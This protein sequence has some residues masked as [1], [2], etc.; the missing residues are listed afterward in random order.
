MMKN[1]PRV[2]ASTIEQQI[3]V[4]RKALK[5]VLANRHDRHN[6]RARFWCHVYLRSLKEIRNAGNRNT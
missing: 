3:K 2:S 1:S 6:P 4:L 5:R